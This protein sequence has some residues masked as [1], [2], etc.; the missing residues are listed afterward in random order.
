MPIARRPLPTRQGPIRVDDT[1]KAT[2]AAVAGELGELV[3][4]CTEFA[5]RRHAELVAAGK[6]EAATAAAKVA[7][8]I[9]ECVRE[10][11]RLWQPGG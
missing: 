3:Q 8:E 1:N 2:R 6:P 4:I 9:A 11:A 7:H 10:R 5:A